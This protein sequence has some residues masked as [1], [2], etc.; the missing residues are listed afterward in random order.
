MKVSLKKGSLSTMLSVIL[1]ILVMVSLIS[2]LIYAYE[3]SLEGIKSAASQSENA[4]RDASKDVQVLASS[5]ND[6]LIL[7]PTQG[8]VRV[9]AVVKVIKH[10]DTI[11]VIPVKND[12]ELS[13]PTSIGCKPKDLMS[14]GSYLLVLLDNGN[15]VLFNPRTSNVGFTEEENKSLLISTLRNLSLKDSV[16]D[17]LKLS[18]YVLEGIL[19][20]YDSFLNN[21][22]PGS[23]LSELGVNY[24]PE[25]YAA[26]RGENVSAGNL[27]LSFNPYNETYTIYV[28]DVHSKFNGATGFFIMVPLLINRTKRLTGDLLFRFHFE[29]VQYDFCPAS[30]VDIK[31]SF[32]PVEYAVLPEDFYRTPIIVAS[33][34]VIYSG[35]IRYSVA[36]A[37]YA[38]AGVVRTVDLIRCSPPNPW[39]YTTADHSVIIHFD[40]AEVFKSLPKTVDQVV[41]VIGMQIAV[42]YSPAGLMAGLHSP[43]FPYAKINFGVYEVKDVKVTIPEELVGVPVLVPLTA[44]IPDVS[45]QV[46]DPRGNKVRLFLVSNV[47]CI[48]DG[49]HPYKFL[50][51]IPSSAGTYTLRYVQNSIVRNSLNVNALK[52]FIKARKNVWSVYGNYPRIRYRSHYT[53]VIQGS[54]ISSSVSG[55]GTVL[56]RFLGPN[57]CPAGYCE[58]YTVYGNI[59]PR[60][61]VSV[62]A[63]NGCEPFKA[64]ALVTRGYDGKV[65]TAIVRGSTYY[66]NVSLGRVYSVYNST[67]H[68]FKAVLIH[69]G[70]KGPD[71]LY[72]V[73]L[74]ITFKYSAVLRVKRDGV[75]AMIYPQNEGSTPAYGVVL[76]NEVKFLK[77]ILS[78]P[79]A[80]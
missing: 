30:V 46:A 57:K 63:S 68:E 67:S 41:L 27:V 47:N 12:F 64:N 14:E 51:F 6:S 54:V 10:S 76:T 43:K 4:V 77:P 1:G 32:R 15:Y 53:L 72:D 61:N 20:N 48:Y 44:R 50:A 71:W 24:V 21:P 38:K 31:V 28:C 7:Q 79:R 11:H 62:T 39:A 73:S 37:L 49:K 74:T 52:P 36:R 42:R 5:I 23:S 29:P 9:L 35:G 59:P 26:L 33:G 80:S 19:T 55:E 17:L 75:I 8:P 65:Q 60:A 18:P 40:T 2:T 66:C 25:F 58:M 34:N 22:D 69:N 70:T 78:S 45:L 3:I 13:R 56:D 16:V